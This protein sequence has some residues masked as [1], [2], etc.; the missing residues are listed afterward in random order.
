[1]ED[2]FEFLAKCR[3]K[4]SV[5]PIF[6][7][8]RKDAPTPK[9]RIVSEALD[10]F[11]TGYNAA[12]ETDPQTL[13]KHLEGLDVIERSVMLEGS[14][15]AVATMDL[16]EGANWA[17]LQELMAAS[18][19]SII[20]MNEGI[21]QALCQQRMQIDFVPKV[22]ATFWGWLAV[23]GYGCH[24]GY[25]RWPETIAQQKIPACLDEIGIK[26]FDQ[27]VGRAM[28]MMGAADPKT[29]KRLVNNFPPS[30]R[31]DM[32][33]GVGM[34]VGMWGADD[35][36]DMRRFLLAS[37]RWRPWLQLGVSWSTMGRAQAGQIMD[38]T[39][40]ACRVI[41]G[42]DDSEVIALVARSLEALGPLTTSH[43]FG[44]WKDLM[45]QEYLSH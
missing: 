12:I 18:S 10:L 1:M 45:A 41:C 5:V 9:R 37:G 28:W 43:K 32:W 31:A 7:G 15:T 17:N 34:M 14:Y 6:E 44:E 16:Q 27:G 22:T 21:G 42:S 35:S 11:T 2:L 20:A 8:L 40:D 38:Y 3:R 39:R 36:K 25:F 29:I 24:A 26:A 33:S 13:A 23:D 19:D 4:V 30:R